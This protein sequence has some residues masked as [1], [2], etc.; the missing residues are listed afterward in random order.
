ML[1]DTNQCCPVLTRAVAFVCLA[2]FIAIDGC[3]G[4]SGPGLA[5]REQALLAGVEQ[6]GSLRERDFILYDPSYRER[7][8]ILGKRL[9]ALASALASVQSSRRDVT[10]SEQQ[11]HD[12]EAVVALKHLN[13]S[14]DDQGSAL[15]VLETDH[16]RSYQRSRLGISTSA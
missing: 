14:W 16:G 2:S 3:S 15:L 11:L 9:E 5:Y 8:E 4:A 13:A 1:S 10:C 12:Y 7:R 6:I